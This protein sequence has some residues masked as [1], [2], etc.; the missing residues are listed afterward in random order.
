VTAP[1]SMHIEN[2]PNAT[3]TYKT[4]V[5]VT[6][7]KYVARLLGILAGLSLLQSSTYLVL[8]DLASVAQPP[9]LTAA[10]NAGKFVLFNDDTS[11]RV[12]RGVNSLTT[13]TATVTESMSK[14]LVVEAMDMIRDDIYSTFKN[15][16][17]GKFKNIYDNQVLLISSINS[18]FETLADEGVLDSGYEN[19][20]FVDV[21]AQRSAWLSIGKTEAAEWDDVTVRK[22]TFRSNVYLGGKIKIADAMEDFVFNITME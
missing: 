4:N 12:A 15:T 16:Y 20:A 18:Y 22:N 5:T 10:V 19:V 9:D 21:E 6:G 14:I 13:Y 1:D 8:D 3:A 11:V 17:T 2:F 7:E